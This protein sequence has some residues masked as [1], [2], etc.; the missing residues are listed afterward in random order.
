MQL[1][2]LKPNSVTYT[3]ILPACANLAA[4]EHGKEIHKDIIRSGLQS[5]T[6]VDNSLVDM[7]AKCGCLGDARKVFDNMLGRNVVSWS[8]MIIG[9]AMHGCGKEALQLFEQ[10]QHSG[11]LPNHITF[12]GVLSA[13]CHAGL[14]YD[15]WQY[16]NSMTRNYCIAPVMEH[17]CCIVDLLGRAGFLDEAQ[18]FINRM[19]TKPDAAIWGSLLS[20][21]RLHTNVEI[22]E[23]AA[24]HLLKL[25]PKNAANYVLLSNIYAM[26]G[27]WENAEKVRKLMKDRR[28]E[29]IPGCSWIEIDNK[30]YSFLVGERLHPQPHK[31]YGKFETLSRQMKDVGRYVLN[32]NFALHDVEEEQKKNILFHRS[33]NLALPLGL[34][35]HTSGH[36]SGLSKTLG[37]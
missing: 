37:V 5:D 30:V 13:C 27:M 31:I 28:I 16:F 12:L 7:Y 1:T 32:T 6:V 25:D 18:D 15:G 24:Q 3:T 26:A 4:L 19:P 17:Y 2:V 9:Y 35:R 33:E 29:K 34:S 10:M 22:G 23:H 11:T 8:A 21:C 14:V 20:A 36:L